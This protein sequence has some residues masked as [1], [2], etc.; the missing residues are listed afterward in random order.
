M[1]FEGPNR[2]ALQGTICEAD[3]SCTQMLRGYS[4][5]V[6]AP[7]L[8]EGPGAALPRLSRRRLWSPGGRLI[9]TASRFISLLN[10]I[11]GHVN[12]AL[13]PEPHNGADKTGMGAIKRTLH[14]AVEWVILV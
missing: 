5:R 6:P 12:T 11:V 7:D 3:A 14:R 9:D 4:I 10:I 2:V 1:N 8:L 13:G